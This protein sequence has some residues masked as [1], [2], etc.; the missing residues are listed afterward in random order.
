VGRKIGETLG[1]VE[2]VAVAD[3]DVGWGKSLRKSK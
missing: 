2:E 1:S 3:D